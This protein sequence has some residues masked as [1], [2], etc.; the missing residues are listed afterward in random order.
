MHDRRDGVEESQRGFAG[1]RADRFGERGEVRGPVAMMTLSQSAGGRPAISPRSIVDQR[2]GG[3][4]GVDRGRKTVA[5]DRQRAA[6]R[7]LMRVGGGA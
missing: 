7:H 3:N 5:V 4:R 1:E 6:G 2:L